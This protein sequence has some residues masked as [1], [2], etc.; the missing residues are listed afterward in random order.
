MKPRQQFAGLSTEAVDAIGDLF[1]CPPERQPYDL[2]ND[3]QG[4]WAVNHRSES[5]NIRLLLWPAVN[6]ID[7][8][9]GPHMWVVKGVREIETIEELELIARFGQDGVLTVARTGQVVLTTTSNAP[10]PPAGGGAEAR[11][12]VSHP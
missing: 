1:R 8:T 3:N 4:V 2:P 9:V 7:V 11:G 6:R 5:G 12:G 10:S